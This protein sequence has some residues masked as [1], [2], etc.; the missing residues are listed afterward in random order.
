MKSAKVY[1][2]PVE[3]MIFKRSRPEFMKF[4]ERD[5]KFEMKTSYLEAQMEF[6]QQFR[7]S[8]KNIKL[9]HIERKNTIP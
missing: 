6:F 2:D 4:L 8:V 1:M 3:E 9:E 7:K 5:E